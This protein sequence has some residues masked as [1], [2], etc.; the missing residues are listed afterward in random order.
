MHSALFDLAFL[1]D[2]LPQRFD[3]GIRIAQRLGYGFLFG[4]GGGEGDL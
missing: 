2:E 3:E 1:D 4:F